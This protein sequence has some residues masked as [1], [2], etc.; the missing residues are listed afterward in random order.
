VLGHAVRAFRNAFFSPGFRRFGPTFSRD[1]LRFAW[2]AARNWGS[3]APGTLD[4]LGHCLDYPN[5]SHALFLVHDIFVNGAYEFETA[6]PRPR[7]LDCGANVGFAVLFLKT[8]YPEASVIAFEPDPACADRLERTV[9]A[10]GLRDVKIEKAGVGGEDGTAAFYYNDAERG[11]ITAS[12]V[13][14]WGGSATRGIRMVRLSSFVEDGVDFLKLDVEGA[15][16]AVIRELVDT[17]AIHRVREAV[18]E[19]HEIDSEPHALKQMLEALQ[20]EGFDVK[21]TAAERQRTG[22]IRARRN[23]ELQ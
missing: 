20:R 4:W 14:S 5:Q 6:N 21:Q 11:S 18:I 22:M 23:R 8:R 16:Y 13:A 17:G 12:V 10:N 7:I 1:Y 15:E 2:R 3:T 9:A 19:Y